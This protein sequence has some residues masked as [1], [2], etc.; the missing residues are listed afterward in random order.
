LRVRP[1]G[2]NCFHIAESAKN[3]AD[4]VKAGTSALRKR[5]VLLGPVLNAGKTAALA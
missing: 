1:A 2:Q 3:Y 5:G 4:A